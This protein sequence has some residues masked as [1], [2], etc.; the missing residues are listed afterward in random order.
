MSP[1]PANI[2]HGKKRPIWTEVF[3]WMETAEWA[4]RRICRA[5]GGNCGADG[6]AA[7]LASGEGAYRG[8]ESDAGLRPPWSRR[9]AL[10]S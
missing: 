2:T 4:F 8:G 7:A 10:V 1:E 9:H 6:T 3:A 5:A